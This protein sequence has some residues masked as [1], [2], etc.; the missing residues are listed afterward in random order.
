MPRPVLIAP[1]ILSSD[2]ARLADEAALMKTCKADWLH[3]DVMDGHFVP[4]LTIGAPVVK[5]LRKVTDLPLDCHLMIDDPH[6]YGPQFVE[7]GAAMVTFH[8]E[9]GGDLRGLCERIREGGAKVGAAVKPGTPAGPALELLDLLDM[10]L[11]M[12]VEPGFGGQSYMEDMAPKIQE[13]RAAIGD[14]PIDLQVDGGLNSETVIH[15]AAAGANVIVAGSAVFKAA[16]RA[17]AIAAL[18][19]GAEGARQRL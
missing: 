8:V 11:V 6:T 2:F 16:D 3:V 4:N 17:A 10:V 9:V 7:A 12:T 1:S 5:A 14:R 15:A 19:S 13:I 18:R